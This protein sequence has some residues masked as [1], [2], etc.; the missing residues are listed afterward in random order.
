MELNVK[1]WYPVVM[2][3]LIHPSIDDI[4]IEGIL[5][6]LADPVRVAIYVELA[7]SG[8][9]NICSNFLQMSDRNIPKSTL[10]QHFRALREAGLVRSERRGVEMHNTARCVEVEKRFP[11]LL[12]AIMNAYRI[13]S[14]DCARAAKRQQ[15]AVRKKAV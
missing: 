3:P 10:S 12:A 1:G 13:Q 8:C 6:A 15:A 9:A 2:R 5:H 7:N 14:A 4:T 11:G